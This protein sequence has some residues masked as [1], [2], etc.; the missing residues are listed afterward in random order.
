MTAT[1]K[2]GQPDVRAAR[3]VVVRAHEL[4]RALD[5][6]AKR[7]V[8]PTIDILPGGIV[9]LHP[10]PPVA[11]DPGETDSKA[12]EIWDAAFD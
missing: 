11:N 3:K 6:L 8:T 9:R 1:R 2:A 10:L 7:G 5:V 4:N 12:T